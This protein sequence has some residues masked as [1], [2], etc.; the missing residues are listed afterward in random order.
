MIRIYTRACELPSIWDNIFENNHYMLKNK[1]VILEQCNACNQRY[2]IINNRSAF[3]IYKLKLNM[4]TYSKLKLNITVNIIG[5]PCSVSKQGY[6][7]E[8]K[9]ISE[10]EDYIRNQ[11]KNCIILNA[12]KDFSSPLFVKGE[13]LPTCKLNI[14]WSSFDDFK[15]NLRSHYRYRLTKALNKSKDILIEK[16]E[17]NN[18]FTEKLYSLYENVYYKS[19][20]KLEKLSIDF[21]KR[22]PSSIYV[23][24]AKGEPIAFVQLANHDKE[25][26]FLFGGINY[27]LNHKYD[28]Y[29]NMIAFILRHG[30]ENKYSTIDMGQ[31]AEDTKMKFGCSQHKKFMHIYHPN[32]IIR[33]LIK[34]LSNKL[35]YKSSDLI[36]NLYKEE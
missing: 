23:F 35:S 2:I 34:L 33:F 14:L 6:I 8:V 26:F 29:M 19:Q 17:N 27:L 13:T 30:I 36:L 18:L 22:L 32:T 25:L 7:L 21:F 16:L 5:V 4:F 28:S 31:T 1:L 24:Y 10:F 3:V 15:L 9:D 11:K 20:Y 12:E